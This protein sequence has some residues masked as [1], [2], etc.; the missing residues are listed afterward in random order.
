MESGLDI[1]SQGRRL[2]DW[3]SRDALSAWLRSGF[4]EVE[5]YCYERLLS[6]GMP[7][8]GAP[9]RTRTQ[10]RQLFVLSVA[11]CLDWAPDIAR[12]AD[13]LSAFI[14][15]HCRQDSG[16]GYVRSVSAT[17]A[18]RDSSHD[19]YD[20]ACFLLASA[21]HYRAFGDPSSIENAHS[22]FRFLDDEL[23]HPDGGWAEGD[24]DYANRRQNPHMHMFEALLALHDATAD[25]AWLDR[26]DR[27]YALFV[28]HFFDGESGFLLEFF[29]DKLQPVRGDAGRVVEPGHMMEWVW[30]L[31]WYERAR[32]TPTTTYAERLFDNALACGRAATGLLFDT[33]G[34]DGN[35]L[36]A[37]TRLWPMPEMIKAALSQARA[38]DVNGES[39]ATEAIVAF[40]AQFVSGASGS[41]YVDQLDGQGKVIDD[42]AAA[43]SMYHL[44]TAAL[45]ILMKNGARQEPVE[46]PNKL[47]RKAQG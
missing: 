41:P 31:R 24:Y 9:I 39:I 1:E 21:W 44:A 33:V 42:R 14:D 36:T 30:L 18:T 15:R 3:L 19:L 11:H 8:T 28:N 27:V 12:R 10:A 47:R 38:G 32:G 5:G 23:A 25:D 13:A 37:T 40:F 43:S 2:V 17:L 26:A 7:D 6:D 22:I 45:E 34:M 20:H 46:S 16:P 29:D 4:N 35:A